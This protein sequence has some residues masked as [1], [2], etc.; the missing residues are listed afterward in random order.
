MITPKSS[1]ARHPDVTLKQRHTVREL[2]GPR[3][4]PSWTWVASMAALTLVVALTLVAAGCARAPGV[5]DARPPQV[6]AV[7]LAVLHNPDSPQFRGTCLGC[8]ADIMKRTTLKLGVKDAHAAMVP[9][10]PDYDKNAGVT[11][12]NCRSCHTKVDVV[13]HS[14]VQIRKNSDPR[15]CAA[16]HGKNGAATKKFYAE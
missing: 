7:D 10:M 5:S 3:C 6:D 8:H 13:Q 14:G 12:D 2:Q 9:F 4:R 15:S 11:N 1:G 16:C